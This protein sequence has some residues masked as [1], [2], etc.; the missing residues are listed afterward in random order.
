MIVIENMPKQNLALLTYL[1]ECR[2]YFILCIAPVA[3]FGSRIISFLLAFCVKYIGCSKCLGHFGCYF[4][5]QTNISSWERLY[6]IIL[7]KIWNYVNLSQI[8]V[9]SFCLLVQSVN[10]SCERKHDCMHFEIT[11]FSCKV[12]VMSVSFTPLSWVG[13]TKSWRRKQAA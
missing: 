6:G 12:W 3:D 8:K 10:L 4:L 2:C 11:S 13:V 5:V 7:I 9:N 1:A